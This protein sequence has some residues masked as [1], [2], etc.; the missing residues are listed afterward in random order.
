[1]T[2]AESMMMQI[3]RAIVRQKRMIK[4]AGFEPSWELFSNSFGWSQI[5]ARANNP[6]FEALYERIWEEESRRSFDC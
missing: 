4:K 6:S 1:M 5:K 3:R 2:Q